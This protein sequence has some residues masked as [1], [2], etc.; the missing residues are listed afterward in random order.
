M[1][2]GCK[3]TRNV[4]YEA[5]RARVRYEELCAAKPPWL[6]ITLQLRGHFICILNIRIFG[7]DFMTFLSYVP[8][9]QTI[10]P[11]LNGHSRTGASYFQRDRPLPGKRGLG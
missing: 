10:Q 6:F 9:A 11:G 4:Y 8:P 1:Q 5:D 7:T 3:K 2:Q